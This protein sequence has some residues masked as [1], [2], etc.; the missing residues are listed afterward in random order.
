MP[1]FVAD[2]QEPEE[3]TNVYWRFKLLS[4]ELI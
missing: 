2:S 3:I 4:L 1:D